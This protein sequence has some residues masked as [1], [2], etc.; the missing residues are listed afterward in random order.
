MLKL[1]LSYGADADIVSAELGAALHIT[2]KSDR[3]DLV[4]ILLE[5]GG[6][7]NILS[8]NH[9]T[10]LYVACKG[11]KPGAII[12]LLLK[13]GANVNSKG[14]NGETPLTSVLFQY[15]NIFT[16]GSMEALLQ[17]EQQLDITEHDLEMSVT[18]SADILHLL[19]ARASHIE[20]IL[21]M[22]MVTNSVGNFMLL[23]QHGSGNTITADSIQ[24][25]RTSLQLDLL[26]FWV[27]FAPEVRPPT[28]VIKAI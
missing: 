15:D 21:G 5:H 13:H 18:K 7:V 14:G 12:R 3:S 19:L 27:E 23:V 8:S 11:Y 17:S 28:A 1:L 2:I 10:P 25:S 6:N 24:A 16:R 20:I 26:E 9:G 4:K 22:L